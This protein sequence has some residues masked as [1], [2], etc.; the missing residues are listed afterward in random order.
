L[1][2]ARPER[3]RFAYIDASDNR[4]DRLVEPFRLVFTSRSWYLVAYDTTRADWRTFR[5]DRM[6]ELK[7]TGARFA[8]RDAPDAATMVAEGVAVNAYSLQARVRLHV[9]LDEARMLVSRTIGILEPDV[10]P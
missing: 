10:D 4:S 7:L 2:C 1:A 9:P 5:V 3:L 6:G 8:H